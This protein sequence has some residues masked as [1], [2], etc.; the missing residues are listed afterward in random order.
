ML[1]NK[2]VTTVSIFRFKGFSAR[3]WALSQMQL[4]YRKMEGTPG[5]QF[6]K[7]L[8]SGGESGFSWKPDWGKY[9]L[10]AVWENE[11]YA[12]EFIKSNALLRTYVQRSYEHLTVVLNCRSVHG[13]WSGECPFIPKEYDVNGP[14]KKS[15]YSAGDSTGPNGHPT[16][17]NGHPAEPESGSS[18]P[19]WYST[20]HARHPSGP[21][22]VITRATIKPRYLL[23]FWRR[24]AP[25]AR[26]LQSYPERR[27]SVGIGEWPIVQ[28]ATFSIWENQDAMIDFAYK[29]PVHAAVVKMNREEGW[30]D[31][32]L[33]ARFS[34]LQI[35]GNW[36]S[37]DLSGL[38][39]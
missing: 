24:V 31:E 6:I 15:S 17:P 37:D 8:G 38:V 25:V 27:L 22:A 1:M 11:A 34:I 28:Q 19:T 5:L 30:F 36:K 2:S 7:L 26:S 13:H 39:E 29:N 32:E 3:L 12:D 10:L 23:R 4:G 18:E 20:G 9:A 35:Q 14:I 16:E 33:F 21:M